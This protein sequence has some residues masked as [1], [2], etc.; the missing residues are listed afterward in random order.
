MRERATVDRPGPAT[1]STSV[2]LY[3]LP[4]TTSSAAAAAYNSGVGALLSVQQGALTALTESV[5]NDPTFAMG[6]AALALLGHEYCAPIDLPARL[7]SARHHA[8][9]S[10]GRERSHIHAVLA[11]VVGDSGPLLAHLHEHPRDALLLSVAVPT[12]AFA[13]VT[14]VPAQARQLVEDSAPA[15]GSDWWFRGLLAFV[16]QEQHWYD[17]AYELACSSLAEEPGAGHSVHARTHV[18]YETGDHAAGLAWIDSWIVERGRRTDNLTHFAWHAALH[19]LAQCDLSAVR[20]AVRG[21]A[22]A[23]A[24]ERLPGGRRLSLL[25]V[26]VVADPG[27]CGVAVSRATPS[28]CRGRRHG[29]AVHRVHGN[30]RSSGRLR[31]R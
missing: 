30:A 14:T 29:G 19:E 22:R 10:S 4:L 13:G 6:H 12:I 3:G 2:D 11:H 18:H 28:R 9:R 7:A 8:A 5:T 16:R 25:A 31:S 27:R 20:S 15:Y 1:A 24:V 17:E 21:A 23:A 26:A